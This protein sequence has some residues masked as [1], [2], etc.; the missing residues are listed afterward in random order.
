MQYRFE[1]TCDVDATPVETRWFPL[2]AILLSFLNT[3]LSITCGVASRD[4]A[5]IHNITLQGRCL[6][7]VSVY[8]GYISYIRRFA[9]KFI[10]RLPFVFV[11][12]Y[13]IH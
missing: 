11:A 3:A 6:S 2:H 10:R 4:I 13:A 9:C 7:F 12:F 1:Y 5:Y 8:F